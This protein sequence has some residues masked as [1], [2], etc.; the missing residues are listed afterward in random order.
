MTAGVRAR[1]RRPGWRAL[2]FAAVLAAAPS[3]VAAAEETVERGAYVFRAAGCHTCHTADD[4]PALAGGRALETPFGTFRTP[5]I[6][7]HD[8]EGIGS[9]GLEDFTRALRRGEAPGGAP[10][11]PSFPYTSYAGMTDEDVAALF[12]YLQRREPVARTN[13]GHDLDFPYSLRPLLR[14]WRF[15]FFEPARFEADPEKSEQWNRGAYLVRHLAHCGECHTPRNFLGAPVESRHLAGADSG[16]EGD[17]VP[18]ITPHPED[19]IGDWGPRDIVFYLQ[20]GFD[21]DGDVA[22]GAMSDVIDDG[23]S[24]LR[25]ADLEAIAAYLMSLPARPDR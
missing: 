24:H 18:N 12:A 22:G 13:R 11:Y 15:L 3:A 2:A 21:P 16:P 14:V 1:A 7:P 10:Y 23:T 20:T 25:E 4:G 5:N 17:P 6:T 19:G 8:S 9:W